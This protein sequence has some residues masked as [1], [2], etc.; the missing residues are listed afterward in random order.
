MLD[1]SIGSMS[2]S[3]VR[4]T[5]R[6]RKDSI[7][8][9]PSTIASP[10]IPRSV[11]Q[12]LF[13]DD[14][15]LSDVDKA[16]SQVARVGRLQRRVA[17]PLRAP[18]VEMKYCSTFRPSRKFAMIGVSMISPDGRHQTAHTGELADLLLRYHEHPSRP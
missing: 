16:A 10:E 18:C 14:H 9:P 4:P 11:P 2:S 13:G 6:S 3:V 15:V 12:S 5:I 1:P 17:R 7:F 8:S